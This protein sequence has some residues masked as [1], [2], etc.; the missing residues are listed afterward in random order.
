[1]HLVIV[2][3]RL[4]LKSLPR[5]TPPD[6]SSSADSD[7]SDSEGGSTGEDL[8]EAEVVAVD[9]S[10]VIIHER[11][12]WSVSVSVGYV[13]I[14]QLSVSSIHVTEVSMAGACHCT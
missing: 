2:C 1:M 12:D 6:K 14:F 8:G 11:N 4:S 9:S 10:D 13:I 7:S 3:I 5:S